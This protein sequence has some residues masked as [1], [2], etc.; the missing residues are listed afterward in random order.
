MWIG[1][2][3]ASALLSS[4]VSIL[5]SRRVTNVNYSFDVDAIILIRLIKLTNTTQKP[6]HA[7]YAHLISY[8]RRLNCIP[9]MARSM[10]LCCAGK[11]IKL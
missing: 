5:T 10:N 7:I 4:F 6:I 2:V 8:R 3:C 1:I 11:L 9:T